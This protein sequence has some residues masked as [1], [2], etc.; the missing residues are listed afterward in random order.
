MTE[1]SP[2]ASREPARRQRARERRQA[3]PG[4]ARC[5]I[6]ESNALLIKG[7]NVMLGYWNNP[8]ATKAIL[9]PDGWLNSG[10]TAR[11]DAAG[12]RLHHRAG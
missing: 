11:I 9:G 7:P 3:D 8:D 12:P 2:I 10:D 4:R 5:S 6:G 1:T